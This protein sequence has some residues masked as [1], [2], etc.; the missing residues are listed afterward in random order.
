MR[1]S[2]RQRATYPPTSSIGSPAFAAAE[3]AVGSARGHVPGVPG[4]P[5][6]PGVVEPGTNSAIDGTVDV[7]TGGAHQ[8]VAAELTGAE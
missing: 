1:L 2:G 8:A 7:E 6:D 4:R 3:H 5:L